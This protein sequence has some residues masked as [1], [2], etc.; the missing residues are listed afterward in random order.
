MRNTIMTSRLH[1]TQKLP[2][3]HLFESQTLIIY[4]RK[5]PRQMPEL[6]RW[7]KQMPV[8][9]GVAAGESLK[10]VGHFAGHI[11]K[12][13][14]LSE[15][16][17]PAKMRIVTVGGGSV[18]DFGGFV[19]S[20]LKRGVR[21]SHIPSTWLSA[22]DSAHGGKTA[23]NVQNFK[24]QI[25]TFYAADDVYLVRH[26]LMK[27]PEARAQEAF[28]ELA[29]M[30][31]IDGRKWTRSLLRGRLGGNDLIWKY[32]RPAVEAKYTWVE[33]DPFEEQGIRQ[34]LNLGH[35]FGHVLEASRGT[36]HGLAVAQGLYFSLKWSLQRGIIPLKDYFTCVE[37]L[38]AR[39]HIACWLEGRQRFEPIP[40]RIFERAL[41]HDK[42]R[43]SRDQLNFV[44]LRRWGR[45]FLLR[46][47][48]A[49]VIKE[50]RRQGWT[51]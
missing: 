19:A 51:R 2:G 32:L 48:Y 46:V 16:F 23:L 41:A 34:I 9:Y 28:G 31:L 11:Q 27:Q 35:T 18:G 37:L 21:L 5:L 38:N 20:V 39:L 7:L 6:R 44:F 13:L 42:K 22:L 36:P 12:I 29:K 1:F 33:R 43:S 3:S 40:L 47:E 17:S 45:P 50:A 24:N 4:D 15:N 25:G 49:D 10:D 30:A 14:T 26:V 8:S